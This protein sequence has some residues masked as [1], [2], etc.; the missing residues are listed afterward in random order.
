ML[1]VTSTCLK[2]VILSVVEQYLVHAGSLP[3]DLSDV[4]DKLDKTARPCQR[5]KL[6]V[7][8]D[9]GTAWSSK[10]PLLDTRCSA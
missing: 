9:R 8:A 2:N 4:K 6:N 7:N 1:K 10:M 3:P 5:H